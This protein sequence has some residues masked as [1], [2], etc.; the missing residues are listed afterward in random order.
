MTPGCRRGD[1]SQPRGCVVAATGGARHAARSPAG[2]GDD[3]RIRGG[4]RRR[5]PARR[6][7]TTRSAGLIG[8]GPQRDRPDGTRD[9]GVERGVL[10][11]ADAAGTAH[12]RPRP[13][14]RG[15]HRGVPRCGAATWRGDRPCAE[16]SPPVRSTSMPS[17]IACIATMSRSCHSPTCRPTVVSSTRRRRWASSPGLLACRSCSTP[18]NRSASG[19][20]DVD[21]DRLRPAVG[22]RPQVPRVGHEAPGSSTSAI[23]DRRSAAAAP[24]GPSRR[25]TR[26][27]RPFRVGRSGARRFEHWEHSVAGWLGLGAAVD[28]ALGWGMDRIEATVGAARRTA[29]GDAE[30][31]RR[32]CVRRRSRPLWNRDVCAATAV[33]ADELQRGA[34][35]ARASTARTTHADSSR[36]DVERRT[37]PPLLRLSVHYTTTA[38]ELERRSGGDRRTGSRSLTH[39]QA[40]RLR[41]AHGSPH[42][43]LGR[44]PALPPDAGPRADGSPTRSRRSCARPRRP[45]NGSR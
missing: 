7:S 17:P 42:E 6:P 2:R 37:L 38:D 22:H 27:G 45:A 44:Q 39:S 14:I 18:A 26:R 24:A 25:R 5:R 41:W 3:R 30:R 19:C 33:D 8:A 43:E 4:R 9:S 11:G 31:R 21:G 23:V 1:P 29:A 32:P 20:I 40:P 16:R 10:V 35:G 34:G 15:E 13:R 12:R 36:W 28:H